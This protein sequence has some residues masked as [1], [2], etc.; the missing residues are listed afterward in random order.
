MTTKIVLI[1]PP[2]AGKTSIGKLLAK[3]LDRSFV[4]S[5]KAIEE[6]TGKK[7]TEIFAEDGEPRFRAIEREVVLELLDSENEIISLGGGSVLN[8]DIQRRLTKEEGVVYL[9]VSISNAA[10]RVGFNKDR[11]LLMLNPRQRWI[12]LMEERRPIYE[13]LARLTFLTD[14]KKAEEV[15]SEILESSIVKA[16]L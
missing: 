8:E 9:Q 11:P 10:P 16:A 3:K 13:G 1:G 5:D 14:N 7:I 15:V 6:R 12:Q 4:D 2:G